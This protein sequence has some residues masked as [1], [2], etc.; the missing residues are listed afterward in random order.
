MNFKQILCCLLPFVFAPTHY[1]VAQTDIA[2][3]QQQQRQDDQ[4]RRI[5]RQQQQHQSIDTVPLPDVIPS[6]G[7]PCFDITAIEFDGAD[8]LPSMSKQKL[9]APFLNQCIDLDKINQ[10]LR[11][12]SE[13]YLDRGYVT[14]RACLCDRTGFDDRALIDHRHRRRY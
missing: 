6:L 9:V 12:V 4:R 11:V 7:G 3:Q 14:S 13:W 5:E 2:L 1:A 8:H 10:L